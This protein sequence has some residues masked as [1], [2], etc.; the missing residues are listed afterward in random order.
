MRCRA[1]IVRA[2]PLLAVLAWLG[3]GGG[4]QASGGGR[5]NSS[6]AGNRSQ[7]PTEVLR[8]QLEATLLEN[9]LQ[10]GLGNFEAYA[11]SIARTGEVTLVGIGPGDLVEGTR[12]QDCSSGTA[13]VTA[14]ARRDGC[15]PARDPL[16]FRYGTPCRWGNSAQRPCLGL[17]SKNLHLHVSADGQT[18]WIFDELSF[19]VPHEGREAA[20]PLRFSAVFQRSMDRWIMAMAHMSYPVPDNI[21]AALLQRGELVAPRPMSTLS[22]EPDIEPDLIAALSAIL[23]PAVA[24]GRQVSADDQAALVLFPDPRMEFHGSDIGDMP[25]LG[26][27]LALAAAAP[28]PQDGFLPIEPDMGSTRSAIPAIRVEQPRVAHDRRSRIAWLAADVTITMDVRRQRQRLAMRLT[29]VFERRRRDAP[30][31]PRLIHLSVPLTRAQIE[32][33]VLGA[34]L[35]ASQSLLEL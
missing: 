11:D 10:I 32:A 31:S 30:W 13:R 16:P 27:G 12:P 23:A 25:P 9:Y 19:R 2:V 15:N 4:A 29:A 18:A 34:G 14:A 35:N 7:V 33:R 28:L 3:C 20:M 5:G 26:K 17:S 6:G 1:V 22:D 8:G 24:N 21:T